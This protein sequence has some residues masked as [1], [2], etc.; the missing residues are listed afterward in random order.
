MDWLRDA[1]GF[2]GRVLRRFHSDAC[3]GRAAG[4]AFSTLFAL[5]PLTAVVFAV[6]SAVGVFESLIAQA[7]RVVVEQL[8]PAVATEVFE[9]IAEFTANVE[10]LGVF[11]LIMFGFTGLAL[12][13][14]IHSSLNAIWRFRSES[15]L[16]VRI[17][18]Y[19]TVMLL[20]AVLLAGAIAL[21]PLVQSLIDDGALPFP[22]ILLGFLR[23]VV[24]PLLLFLTL[25]LT[26][27]LVP[28]GNVVP[29][30]AAIGALTATAGWEIAKRVFVVWV[31]SVMRLNVVYG[32]VAAV[33]IFLIWL[34]ISWLIGLMGVEVAYIHQH[35]DELRDETRSDRPLPSLGELSEQT[36][37]ALTS[38]LVRFRT[39]SPPLLVQDLD[40]RYGMPASEVIRESLVA[41][42]LVLDTGAGLI[43]SRDTSRISV[44]DI[45]EGVW[46]DEPANGLARALLREWSMNHDRNAV[47]VLQQYFNTACEPPPAGEPVDNDARSAAAGD[48]PGDPGDPARNDG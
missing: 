14:A 46:T 37:C 39:G 34:Y 21:G 24:P 7:Q 27:V 42:G 36:V 47:D 45:V 18:T 40:E 28:S 15:S 29:R 44:S 4:L 20:G 48:E 2:A 6:L 9:G 16:W 23:I 33:P 11:G 31:G 10:A 41:T 17:S 32:S 38:I 3:P 26:I 5:V 1:A 35:R 30:S 25:F 19:I 22:D 43:P 13:R 8:V 12:I